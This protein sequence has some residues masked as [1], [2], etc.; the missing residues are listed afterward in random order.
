M[1][2][3]VDL[4]TGDGIEALAAAQAAAEGIEGEQ[5]RIAA[6]AR[7][8]LAAPSVVE[9]AALPHWRE[10]YV[11]VPFG[12]T[13]LEGYVDLLYRRDDGLVVVDHKTDR[14]AD[15]LEL[16]GKL[17]AYRLQLAAYALAVERATGET[18]VDARLVFCARGRRE[19]RGRPRRSAPRWPRPKPSSA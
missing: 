5:E 7:S 13:V 1:L 16:A 10:V 19:G 17:A 9:A 11:G 14:V 15:D 6:L 3:V 18:V 2:Q 8:A 4:A 12:D